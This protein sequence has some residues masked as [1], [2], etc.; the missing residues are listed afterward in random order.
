MKYLFISLFIFFTQV[1]V[2]SQE[3]ILT[4]ISDSINLIYH[5][6]DDSFYLRNNDKKN[7]WMV[8]YDKKYTK[9]SFSVFY[10]N[11]TCEIIDY[12]INGFIKRKK[13]VF[14]G[15]DR[16]IGISDTRWYNN[17]Q[18]MV[19]V[20]FST[21]PCI[22]KNY[23][24][25]GQQRFEFYYSDEWLTANGDWKEWYE[26]GNLKSMGYYKDNKK[27]GIWKYYKENGELEKIEEY[28]NGELIKDE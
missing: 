19:D 2:F 1:R 22:V 5:S 18:L 13:L 12:H 26:N 10:Q 7:N 28:N 6:F 20:N 23:Y 24:R 16:I 21:F 14:S 27:H 9:L 11:D 25:N 3:I 4:D 15:T 8:Y 17:G